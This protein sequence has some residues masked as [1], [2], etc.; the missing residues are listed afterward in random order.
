MNANITSSVQ[1]LTNLETDEKIQ[2][3]VERIRRSRSPEACSSSRARPQFLRKEARHSQHW[4]IQF[5]ICFLHL[6]THNENKT[7]TNPL[8]PPT[9]NESGIDT[10]ATTKYPGATVRTGG[11]SSGREIHPDEGGDII[12]RPGE[13][14]GQG[15]V[16]K[17][18]DFE[19]EGGPETK[20]RIYEE[21]N[22]GND[23]VEGNVRQ[24]KKPEGGTVPTSFGGNVVGKDL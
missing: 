20:Q 6:C 7:I 12:S 22:P 1:R 18:S 11:A 10:N 13:Q 16:T 14:G 5:V 19:G 2:N 24:V 21:E 3:H 15:R 4:R 23:D 9:A 17:D 8:T